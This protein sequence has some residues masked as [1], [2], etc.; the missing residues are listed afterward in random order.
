MKRSEDGIQAYLKSN[1]FG[2]GNE[3]H[4][5]GGGSEFADV[6]SR[7]QNSSNKVSWTSWGL[8]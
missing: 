4:V 2:D 5:Y 6:K 8:K 1:A 7:Y 3:L